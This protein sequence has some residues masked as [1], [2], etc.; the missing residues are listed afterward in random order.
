M[1]QT[2]SSAMWQCKLTN[3]DSR[4][5]LH[6]VCT[7]L[8]HA[9]EGYT[10]QDHFAST[11]I[12]I[13]SSCSDWGHCISGVSTLLRLMPSVV[14]SHPMSSGVN[15]SVLLQGIAETHK[16][17]CRECKSQMH[18]HQ[19]FQT[20]QQSFQGLLQKLLML[21]ER[22]PKGQSLLLKGSLIRHRWKG[23][24]A[25][26]KLQDSRRQVSSC[27][28]SSPHMMDNLCPGS[29][30][31]GFL[32][33]C[34]SKQLIIHQSNSSLKDSTAGEL[35]RGRTVT[36]ESWRVLLQRSEMGNRR[37]AR[38]LVAILKKKMRQNGRGSKHI[39]RQ[40]QGMR[41]SVL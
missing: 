29:C 15:A 4:Q 26:G 13:R 11:A 10:C 19:S 27:L 22:L 14:Q 41:V 35:R 12:P 8:A 2:L 28:C 16:A 21:L 32:S 30:Y 31:S 39:M 38:Q 6:P 5:A 34:D 37:L 17:T 3:T 33:G 36:S 23:P 9:T 25:M 7:L 40:V 1:Q 24:S 20:R 18:C